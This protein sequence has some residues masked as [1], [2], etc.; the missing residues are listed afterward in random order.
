MA[1]VGAG[2]WNR[3]PRLGSGRRGNARSVFTSAVSRPGVLPPKSFA[4]GA[5]AVN[6]VDRIVSHSVSGDLT[7]DPD[8]N[9]IEPGTVFSTLSPGLN[10]GNTDSTLV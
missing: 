2:R 5:E 1:R 3:F 6:G 8:G 9:R 7:C 10:L 4:L